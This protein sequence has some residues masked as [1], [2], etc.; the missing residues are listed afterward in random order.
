MR[1]NTNGTT[2]MSLASSSGTKAL[3][4]NMTDTATSG[5]GVGS[6]M[7]L[8]SNPASNSSAS[9]LANGLQVQPT[10][11]ATITY[12][13]DYIATYSQV[14]WQG[15][16]NTS[17]G[18]TIGLQGKTGTSAGAGTITN[19][20]GVAAGNNLNSTVTNSFALKILDNAGSTAPTNAYGVYVNNM[21][22]GTN[23]YPIYVDSDTA[24]EPLLAIN[25]TGQSTFR[26][27][28][29]S[30]TAFQ[31]QTATGVPVLKADTSIGQIRL[32]GTGAS[33]R[34]TFEPLS[35]GTTNLW[36][37]D[38]QAGTLRFYR[39]NWAAS[40]TGA[41]GSVRLQLSDAGG[42]ITTI[43]G[44]NSCTIGSGT[45]TTTC[46]SDSRLKNIDGSATGNLAKILQLQ[47]TYYKWKN[48]PSST[49]R[50][51]LIAQ[52]VQ[53]VLPEYIV[54]GDDG[55]LQLDYAGLVT[56]LIGAV[57]EQQAQINDAKARL[58]ALENIQP[59]TNST[60]DLTNGGTIQGTLNV[61]G[62]LNVSGPTTLA[63][64]T[65]TGDVNIGGNL[66]VQ[67]VQVA[68]ITV[69]GHII[70]AGNAPVA[71]AGVAAGAEDILN[72]I[73]SPTV[74]IT[75]NDTSGTITVVAGANTT[76]DELAKVTF[77]NP[78]ASKP[79]VIFSPANR[80]STKLGAYYDSNATTNTSFS[81]MTD[82]APQP[83]KTYTFTY[84]ITQ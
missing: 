28:T 21:T 5:F 80:D 6:L 46:T 35:S 69:N 58:T 33:S 52:N 53:T 59:A 78:F 54:T 3:Q 26:N 41:S 32:G 73:A 64:L 18:Q 24:N 83:G 7:N 70:T 42:G 9:I 81:I 4:V 57:Q 17:T 20:I 12:S 8:T 61:V 2:T 14:N 25:S 15:A 82:Q 77:N 84:W 38:N 37:V 60:F 30:A 76:A 48:D 63:S 29:D 31:I 56:P 16:G 66:T 44:T 40:G 45:G 79:R 51:G 39:E 23:K 72:N 75:G 50:L 43:A 27:S 74:Q 22:S 13:G 10:S 34:L 36:N 49:Q 62:N 19:A 68:N 11:G 55:Y 71:V 1:F 67:N 65:V 47:P